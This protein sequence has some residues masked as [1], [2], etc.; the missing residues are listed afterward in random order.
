MSPF[1]LKNKNKQTDKQNPQTPEMKIK[2]NRQNTNKRKD[3]KQINETKSPHTNERTWTLFCVG[4]LLLGMGPAL[5]C[6]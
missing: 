6:G 1:S 5:V 3:A 2:P 4:Q